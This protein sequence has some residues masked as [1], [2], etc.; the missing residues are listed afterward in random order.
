M[1]NVDTEFNKDLQQDEFVT[2][3]RYG[4]KIYRPENLVT[5]LSDPT[6][7]EG[8]EGNFWAFSLLVSEFR[9]YRSI[10]GF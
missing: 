7:E 10:I 8:P 9:L 6:K 5:V 2:T 3:C 1:P 4:I